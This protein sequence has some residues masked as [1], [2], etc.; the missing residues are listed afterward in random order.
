M[1]VRR[2]SSEPSE[3]GDWNQNSSADTTCGQAP[4]CEKIVQRSLADG[5]YLCRLLAAL[6]TN[7]PPAVVNLVRSALCHG[8]NDIYSD[9][10]SDCTILLVGRFW[11]TTEV[12][13]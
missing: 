3:I 12:V 13:H 1:F 8:P 10:P 7:Q 11:V 4:R 6:Q 2:A 9:R 5:E